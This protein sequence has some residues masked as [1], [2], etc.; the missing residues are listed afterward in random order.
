MALALAINLDLAFAEAAKL[1]SIHP[2]TYLG[3]GK[4]VELAAAVAADDVGLVVFN[5]DL[6]AGPAAQS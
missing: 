2:K 3:S 4:V 5:G 1:S 6:N